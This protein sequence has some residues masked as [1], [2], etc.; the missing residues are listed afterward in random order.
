MAHT[1]KGFTIIELVLATAIFV[2]AAVALGGIFVYANKTQR[3]AGASVRRDSDARFAF[4]AM[5]REVRRGTIDYPGYATEY[6][7]AI[8]AGGISDLR[9][10]NPQ[11]QLLLFQR[12]LVGGKGV[13]QMSSD[14]VTWTNLT[15]STKVD[16]VALKFYVAPATDPFGPPSPTPPNIQPYVV[17]TASFRSQET[18]ATAPV[19]TFS[20]TISSRVYGR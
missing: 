5:A 20:T 1:R 4:E 14:G 16:V 9:L 10:I 2:T 18:D 19:I 8:P 15:S 3:Y 13:V 11:G 7:G 6:G 17:M 12:A